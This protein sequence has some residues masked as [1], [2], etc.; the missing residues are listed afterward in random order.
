MHKSLL[1]LLLCYFSGVSSSSSAADPQPGKQVEMSFTAK[2][3][4]VVPYLLYLPADYDAAK[5]GLPLVLFLHG[6]GESN[7]ALSIVSTWGPPQMAARGNKLPYVLVSP[8]CPK[9]DNW[10]SATQQ[11]RLTELLDSVIQSTKADSKRIYLTGLSMGGSGSWRMAADQPNRF[12]AVIPICGGAEVDDAPKLKASKLWVWV[13]DGDSVH[14][15]NVK[16]LAALK[17][18][19]N[20][21]ARL[22]VLEHVGHNSWSAAYA[23]PDLT[24]WMLKQALP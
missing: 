12:A 18:A 19:G 23:T 21:S 24:N 10:K 5:G 7:G 11:A 9:E 2:D 13:G 16:M 15:G 8:Q 4:G 20:D 3:G 17:A 6:R 22:T 1:I 14:E